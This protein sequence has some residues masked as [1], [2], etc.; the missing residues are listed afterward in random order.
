MNLMPEPISSPAFKK[1][2]ACREKISADA[3][4]CPIC[5][6]PQKPHRWAI[7]LSVLKWVGGLTALISLI[8][9]V[10]QV[11]TIMKDWKERDYAVRQI[12]EASKMLV[13]MRDYEAAWQIIE[14]GAKIAPSSKKAFD[15]QVDIAMAWLRDIQLQKG[16][17]TYNEIIEPLILTLSQGVGDKNPDRAATILAHIG[18]ANLFRLRDKGFKFEV[19]G[20]FLQ[21][22]EKNSEDT[23]ANLFRGIWLLSKYNEKEDHKN[24][25]AQSLKHFSKALKTG[26]NSHFV[27]YWMISTLTDPYAQGADVEAFKIAN[28]WRKENKFPIEESKKQAISSMFLY[29][30]HGLHFYQLSEGTFLVKLISELSFE[31]I[32]DTFLWLMDDL[33]DEVWEKSKIFYLGIISEANND[34]KTAYDNYVEVLYRRKEPCGDLGRYVRTALCRILVK[35]IEDE[36]MTTKMKVPK[37]LE[38]KVVVDDEAAFEFEGYKENG[39]IIFAKKGDNKSKV[40]L[41]N[42]DILLMVDNDP[43]EDFSQLEKVTEDILSSKKPYVTFFV[44]REREVFCYRFM[45]ELGEN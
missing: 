44:L 36:G 19:D 41:V 2:V 16:K 6:S 27:N 43:I 45:R 37:I 39:L 17:K 25:L 38:N 3:S 35:S 5:R 31:E 11:G 8:I 22:L 21:A 1:C 33:H 29:P 23:Y 34:L 9:G 13:E 14:K 18:W 32:R 30:L 7:L 15:Q 12:V 20:Y 24:R 28:Q 4:I 10:K 40:P 26:E 42:G